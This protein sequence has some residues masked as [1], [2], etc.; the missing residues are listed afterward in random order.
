MQG[1]G[2]ADV[3]GEGSADVQGKGPAYIR[4]MGVVDRHALFD[5]GRRGM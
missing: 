2:S 1:E 4:Y 3:Q 5:C